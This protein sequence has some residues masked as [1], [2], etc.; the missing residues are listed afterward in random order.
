MNQHSSLR[1]TGR[2][3]AYLR[4]INEDPE[5]ASMSF[6]SLYNRFA[7]Y[8][9][10]VALHL[11]GDDTY[12]EDIVQEVFLNCFRKL[13]TLCNT[14]HARR[15]LVKVTVRKARR[16]LR[17]KKITEFLRLSDPCFPEPSMPSVTAD[18][19]AAMVLLYSLLERLPVDCRLAWSL[20]FLDGAKLTEVAHACG[21]SLATAKRRI[22][23]AHRTIMGEDHE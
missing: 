23:V 16:R 19:R 2:G 13:D 3:P 9:A 12:V 17:R 20:R 6:D 7:P 8:V 4:A 18:E 22:H 1:P 5:V 10:S 21:C 11:L 15:W 14:E